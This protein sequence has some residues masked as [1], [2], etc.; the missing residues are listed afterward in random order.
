MKKRVITGAVLLSIV[1]PLIMIDHIKYPIVGILF[2]ILGV[3]LSMVASFEMMNMFYTKYK[4]LK[5]YRFF[6]GVFN[7]LI[8]LGIHYSSSFSYSIEI[9]LLL[10]VVILIM[11]LTIFTKD[12]SA[13]DIMAC[14]TT[15]AYCGLM[16]GY[17]INI[18]YLEPFPVGETLIYL[19]GGRSF[20]YLYSIVLATDTFAYIFGIKFG[21][22][23]LAPDISPKKSVEGAIAGLIG[24]SLF[25]VLVIFL[26]KISN[27]TNNQELLAVII[28]GFFLSMFLSFMVQ[29]GDL[30]AS[31]LK[32]TYEIKD[33][34]TI[35]PG[36]GGVIDRFD[37]LIYAGVAYY[38]IV[39]VL[40]MVL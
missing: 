6:I 19:R 33:F 36:H 2:L 37:S 31:K 39:Q 20:G 17:V 35:F 40:Y 14:I 9:I 1:V 21:K 25:G 18:R 13:Y 30:V 27:H 4:S 22:K 24:G 38:I 7:G 28:T 5:N 10:L 32:R 26:L 8:V 16:F 15:V 12:T 11:L 29:I 34:G 3:F 23:R